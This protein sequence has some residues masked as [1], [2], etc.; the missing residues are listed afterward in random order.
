MAADQGGAL[1]RAQ[2]HACSVTDRM[3][4]SRVR[5]GRWCRVHPGV[6]AIAGSPPSWTG[7]VWAA[8][9]AAGPRTVVSHASALLLHGVTDRLVPRQPVT[10]TAGYGSH[11]RVTGAV[12]HQLR[13][14]RPAHVQRHP[15]GLAVTTP[16]RA[17]VDLAAGLGPRR[18]GPV[19]DEVVA[20]KLASMMQVATCLGEV[21]R[22]GKPGAR[23]RAQMLDDRGPGHVPPHSEL[24]RALLAAL[25]AAELPPPRRQAPLPGRGAVEGLVDA[26][27]PDARLI[28]EADGR[29]WHT[30]I[31]DL[32]RDHQRDA[33]AAR[34]GW[35]ALRF[36]YEQIVGDPTE[37]GAVVRDVR[38]ARRRAA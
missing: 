35:Q 25:A 5:S 14:L 12:V 33:E 4:E 3:I 1:S 9:L 8:A 34:A 15:S 27:Y 22:R 28:L 36:G 16:G 17:V 21:A 10:L 24:E 20:G 18:L 19:L 37:V 23:A 31:R 7:R 29:R 30:R 6:Y 11:H 32:A 26:A 2:A 38:H 13:D